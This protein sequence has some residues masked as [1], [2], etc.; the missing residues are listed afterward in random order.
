MKMYA[1]NNSSKSAIALANALGIKR[2][3]LNGKLF[4]NPQ[5]L[6]LNWGNSSL[7]KRS[8]FDEQQFINSPLAVAT[9]INKL[10]AF[11]TLEGHCPLP[12]FT[13]SRAEASWWLPGAVVCRTVLNGHSGNG[14]VIAETE[15]QLVDAPL[16]TKYIKKEHEYRLHVFNGK[17]F[18]VQKKARSKAV[19][20]ENVNWKI[21]NHG[22]GFIYAH[23]GVDVE[24]ATKQIAVNAVAALGLDFGAV[25]MMVTKAGVWYVLEVNTACGLENTTLEKYVEQFKQFV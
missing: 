20:D 25:D 16:Y 4:K 22:N 19:A 2:L 3:H 10:Q 12:P 5:E 18:H 11:K 24:D 21:R 17:V 7:T 13:E 8:W 15:E 1:Y 9:A 23:V 14:I 6:I